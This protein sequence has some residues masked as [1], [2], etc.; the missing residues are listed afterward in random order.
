MK[1]VLSTLL[2]L[3]AAALFVVLPTTV[4]AQCTN[5]ALTGSYA[6]IWQG[7]TA[8]KSV[9]GPYVPWA[10]VG[11]LTFDGA[12]NATASW[13]T[14]VDGTI[15]TSQFGAGPY[16]V[17]PDCGGALSLTSGSAAGFTSN[18][19]IAGGGAEVFVLST[20]TG[21]AATFTLKKQ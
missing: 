2:I 19:V 4:H 14:S 16:T 7:F 1:K 8:K 6:M 13:T 17:N 12:G 11:I 10:G 21:D 9:H 5:A 18:L 20:G 15:Y 3:G